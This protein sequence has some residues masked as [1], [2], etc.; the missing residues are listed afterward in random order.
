MVMVVSAALVATGCSRTVNVPLNQV[1]SVR[2]P[3]ARHRIHMIDGTEYAV[4]R[5]TATDST[6]VI[7]DLSPSDTRFDSA[8]LPIVLSR[9]NVQSVT[10][11]EG[12]H[13]W[14]VAGFMVLGVFLIVAL[15][16]WAGGFGD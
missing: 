15:S 12:P 2:D 3:Q 6:I 5:F 8:S 7:D 14:V 11:A 4:R 16:S 1:Q 13:M 9:A 10:R